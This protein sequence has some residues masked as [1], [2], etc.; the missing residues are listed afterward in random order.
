VWTTLHLVHEAQAAELLGIPDG[1][2]QIA[3]IP[4]AY[5]IGTDFKPA[6]R[7]PVEDITYWEQWGG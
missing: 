6:A 5:T 3:L 4:V 2:T 1:V 7:P